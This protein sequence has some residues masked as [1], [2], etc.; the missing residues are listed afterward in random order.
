M[1]RGKA[2]GKTSPC[3]GV[4]ALANTL[5]KHIP[6]AFVFQGECGTSSTWERGGAM[7]KPT[8]FNWTEVRQAKWNLRSMIGDAARPLVKYSS[9]FSAMDICYDAA[10]NNIGNYG[11][12]AA[13]CI[14]HGSGKPG[15]P[16]RVY[17]NKTVDHVKL[18]FAAVQSVIQL[19]DDDIV[20]VEDAMLKFECDRKTTPANGFVCPVSAHATPP[21]ANMHCNLKNTT[22]LKMLPALNAEACRDAC[23]S[24]LRC[25]C[26]AYSQMPQNAG[27]WLQDSAAPLQHIL[28][29]TG[30]KV[31][32]RQNQNHSRIAEGFDP[33]GYAFR[34]HSSSSEVGITHVVVW[35]ASPGCNALACDVIRENDRLTRCNI[36]VTSRQQA[37]A[38]VAVA[39]TPAAAVTV[40]ASPLMV[41]LMNGTV[42]SMG[43]GDASSSKAVFENGRVDLSIDLYDAPLLV[44][45]SSDDMPPINKQD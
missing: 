4:Q 5:A 29:I 42:H 35:D 10:P 16:S 23:C 11:L 31:P 2:C 38:K 14:Q 27:C 15:S 17:P 3:S 25:T 20:P 40:A 21:Q 12:L 6:S 36:T 34:N 39:S 1:Q 44:V 32:P 45:R 43:G 19:F 30:G 24:N 8:G 18:A 26:W 9:V 13:T 7:A 41:V 33:I 22:H 28:N 37:V